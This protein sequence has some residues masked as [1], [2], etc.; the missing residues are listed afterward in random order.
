[1]LDILT[2]FSYLILP[3]F[4]VLDSVLRH[5]RYTTPRG[6]RLRGAIVSAGA[7]FLSLE[8]GELWGTWMGSAALLDGAA[9]GTAGGAVAGI[10]VYELAHYAYHRLAHTWTPLWRAAHQ[11]HHSPES[12]DALGANYLH[13]L[14]VFFFTS[15]SILVFF[16]LLGLSAEAGA[17]AGAFI[18]FNAAF[19]HANIRTPRW[20]GYVIQRPESHVVHHAR[21]VHRWNYSDLPLW[22]MVF[23]TF[24]NPAVVDSEVGFWTGASAK[25]PSM[26]VGLDV[27]QPPAMHGA[28]SARPAVPSLARTASRRAQP[29]TSDSR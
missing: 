6:W 16:P 18:A 9:L 4:V 20:L 26:L 24:R 11:M 27:T 14:D 1:V 25:I 29:A 13:P 28:L 12:L 19:Q 15:I 22:D 10:L 17:I 5:R 21:G 2:W 7:F 23:G 8:I 3:A